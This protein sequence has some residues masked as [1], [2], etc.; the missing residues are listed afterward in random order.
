M[1]FVFPL[2]PGVDDSTDNCPLVSNVLQ[3]D[4]DSDG[5]GDACDNCP[6]NPNAAQTDTDQNGYGDTCDVIGETNKDMYAQISASCPVWFESNCL[7][8]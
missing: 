2:L 4:T 7:H 5:V 1:C 6:N 3:K 8:T